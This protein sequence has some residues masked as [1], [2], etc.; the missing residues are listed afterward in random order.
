M[1]SATVAAS[2]VEPARAS[3]RL[4]VWQLLRRSQ[5]GLGAMLFLG[6]LVLVAVFAPLL[7]PS[8]PEQTELG[9]NFLPPA[10][11]SAESSHVL[12]TDS[13]GR[14][15]LS[16]VIYGSRVSVVVGVVTVVLAGTLGVALGLLAGYFG[17][18]I[19]DV[20]SLVVDVLLAFPFILLAIVVMTVIGG[21]L[22]NV[23]VV[24]AVTRWVDF[25][26]VVRG[27]TMSVSGR[28]YVL[29]ARAVGASHGRMI[30][31][32][33]LPNVVS[34]VIVIATFAVAQL[35]VAEASLSFLGVGVQ[36]PTPTWG[37]MLADA[38]GYLRT[39]W[40]MATFPGLAIMLTVLAVNF[41]G[42]WV[43]DVLD[44]RISD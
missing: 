18:T 3:K 35:I 29:A 41:I 24:L 27:E 44:P 7:A 40:W 39:A 13:L 14:D 43:R 6:L 30:V 34:P 23:I 12:G 15:I 32:H 38:R 36:P 42:D 22:L 16:R 33:V 1:S 9:S 17:G 8:S 25:A 10:A 5:T 28:D 20:I 37:G 26:R 4:T 11:F 2:E 21:G 19:D 31:R